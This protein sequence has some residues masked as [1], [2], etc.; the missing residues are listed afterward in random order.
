MVASSHLHAGLAWGSA[1]VR[2]L[3]TESDVLASAKTGLGLSQQLEF[4]T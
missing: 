4:G 3:A 2:N 1:K